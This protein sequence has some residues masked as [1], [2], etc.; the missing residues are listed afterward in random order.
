MRFSSLQVPPMMLVFLIATVSAI[1]NATLM[2][3]NGGWIECIRLRWTGDILLPYTNAT[4]LLN[5]TGTHPFTGFTGIA[6]I[7]PDFFALFSGNFL[8]NGGLPV[9]GV[10][11]WG[12]W[13]I[14]FRGRGALPPVATFIQQVPASVFFL[15]ASRFDDHT[16]LIADGGQGLLYRMNLQT[17]AYT[18][19]VQGDPSMDRHGGLAGIHGVHF[20]A[21]YV[22]Y[23]NTFGIGFWKWLVSPSGVPIDLPVEIST[24]ANASKDRPEE[25]VMWIDGST[26][27]P[28]QAG[29][30]Q[31]IAANGTASAFLNVQEPTTCTVG[32]TLADWDVLYIANKYGKVYREPHLLL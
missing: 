8:T 2:Y 12:V 6:E 4:L 1:P 9:L 19:V 5:F 15:G 16:V 24:M 31:K 30:I 13:T 28:I 21:P 18:I 7:Q 25:F 26:Y 11:S 22:Y 20:Q 10:G 29:G 32:R 17:G 14:D 23:S 3:D 27:M